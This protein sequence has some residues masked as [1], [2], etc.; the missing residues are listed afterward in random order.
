MIYKVRVLERAQNDVDGI[1]R[2]LLERS[3]SGAAR[4]HAAFMS[5]SATL[6]N[7]PHRFALASERPALD[8]DVRERLFKTPRGRRYRIVF[9]IVGQE[10]RILRVRGPGQPP[11]EASDL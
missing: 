8:R 1:L 11:L 9:T 6:A 4:W 3:P 10:V 2:W 7:D 5:A